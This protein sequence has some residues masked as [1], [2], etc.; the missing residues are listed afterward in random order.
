MVV[1][2]LCYISFVVIGFSL[3]NEIW[4]LVSIL[5]VTL[6]VILSQ[7]LGDLGKLATIGVTFFSLVLTYGVLLGYYGIGSLESFIAEFMVCVVGNFILYGLFLLSPKERKTSVL[8]W[9]G[10]PFINFINHKI[11]NYF[12]RV[13]AHGGLTVWLVLTTTS[14]YRADNASKNELAFH[15]SND[16]LAFLQ[17]V[18]FTL[19]FVSKKK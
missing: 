12:I 8:G 18:L 1:C 16:I 4:V 9:N 10:N 13:L 7:F 6:M 11:V 15:I 14:E 3:D 17:T 5:V 2:M 19:L